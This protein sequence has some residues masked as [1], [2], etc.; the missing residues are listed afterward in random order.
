MAA[1]FFFS[2]GQLDECFVIVNAKGQ[3]GLAK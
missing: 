2:K 1:G 3:Y